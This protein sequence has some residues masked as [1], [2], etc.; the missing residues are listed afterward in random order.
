MD[1]RRH[2][3]LDSSRWSASSETVLTE[4]HQFIAEFGSF[5]PDWFVEVRF[6]LVKSTVLDQAG[7]RDLC[8]LAL[9]DRLCDRCD[10]LY[11][12]RKCL[13]WYMLYK[14]TRKISLARAPPCIRLAYLRRSIR[15][16][17]DYLFH[18]GLIS[19]PFYRARMAPSCNSMTQWGYCQPDQY[20]RAMAGKSTLD[21]LDARERVKLTRE[22]R[23]TG[24][25][26]EMS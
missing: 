3:E 21:Y 10:M 4:L 16:V 2:H 22:L 25:E 17:I 9:D 18:A 12:A 14:E 19:P 13:L 7:R 20:C 5:N 6:H 24:E 8:L 26:R 11:K 1:L 23:K 15:K